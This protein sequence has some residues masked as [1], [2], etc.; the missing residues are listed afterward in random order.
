MESYP[1][2]SVALNVMDEPAPVLVRKRR[3]RHFLNAR[4]LVLASLMRLAAWASLAGFAW[5]C[6]KMAVTKDQLFGYYGLG[7]VGF[8]LLVQV[9]AFA[10]SRSL[11]CPLCHCS[12]LHSKSC[13]KHQR[14][15]NYFHLGHLFSVVLD[16]LFRRAFSCM[17]CGTEFRLKK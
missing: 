16:V 6:V 3:P 15:R 8:F 10:M 9:V 17:Y 4:L 2:Q 5:C 7:L 14:A 11:S 1:S 13:R 12:V